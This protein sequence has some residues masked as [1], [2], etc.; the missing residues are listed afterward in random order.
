S[1]DGKAR[2][3]DERILV[4]SLIFAPEEQHVYSFWLND[5]LALRRSA[6]YKHMSLLT[7]RT[8]FSSPS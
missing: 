7:E 8:S 6:M 3:V 1:C 2:D 4:G 5:K